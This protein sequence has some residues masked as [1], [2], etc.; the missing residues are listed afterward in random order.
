MIAHPVQQR[1]LPKPVQTPRRGGKTRIS[2]GYPGDTPPSLK[3]AFSSSLYSGATC[4][5]DVPPTPILLKADFKRKPPFLI[6]PSSNP[7]LS[8]SYCLLTDK[9]TSK[10]MGVF[11][12]LVDYAEETNL[13]SYSLVPTTIA[14]VFLG[15]FLL[16]KKEW[17]IH[18]STKFPIVGIESPGYLGLAKARDR[19]AFDAFNIVKNGYYK[20]SLHT[21]FSIAS[22][23]PY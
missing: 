17:S 2:R 14:L 21:I 5:G 23:F 12:R 10:I 7:K 20:V 4:R 22:H 9:L 8:S 13:H 16:L 15:L 3:V 6:H 19:Y 1:P 18:S 11:M